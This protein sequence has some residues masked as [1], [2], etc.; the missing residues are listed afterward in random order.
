MLWLALHFPQLPLELLKGQT[1]PAA[2]IP[3]ADI[4]AADIAAADARTAHVVLQNNRVLQCDATASTAGIAI[5]A[6]LATAHS[7]YNKIVHGHR[8]IENEARRLR[9]LA[10]ALYRFSGHVSIQSPDC[11]LLEIGGSL[12]LF[13]DPEQV[14]DAAIQLCQDLGHC[15]QARL[16]CTPWAAIALARSGRRDVN[17][18]PLSLAGLELAGIDPS[19]IERFANMGIHT[20]EPLLKLPAKSL[21]K[22]FGKVLL[23]YIGQLSGAVPDPR[24]AITLP[25]AFEQQLH[26]LQPIRDKEDL[27]SH[28]RSPLIRLA[29]ELQHWLIAQ[30]L[31]CEELRW[32]FTR[33]GQDTVRVPVRFAKPQQNSADF[34]RVSQLTLEQLEL[35]EEVLSIT[36]SASRLRPWRNHSQNLFSV[37]SAHTGSGCENAD[38]IGAIIDEFN[39]R[40]GQGRCFGMQTVTQYAPEAAC[41]S[42]KA[43]KSQRENA[44]VAEQQQRFFARIGKRPL[45]L[46]DAPRP[47]RREDL[48]LLQGPERIQSSWWTADTVCRDYYIA[49]HS[50]GA[51]CWVFVQLFGENPAEKTLSPTE[52]WY[53]HGYFG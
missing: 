26:L 36:L 27:C 42:A 9:Q 19:I 15:S 34:W 12:K 29:R 48:V 2:D 43:L 30:Q 40:L 52:N 50:L 31:G 6:T 17:A 7:I 18:V 16:A 25:P 24:R 10:Q 44:S 13:G 4:A 38:E 8:N 21:G 41:T 53:V 45:W 28:T 35:P 39:A 23:K 46:F 22:R 14:S 33:H 1:A 5:D 37:A 47:I 3:A 49:L 32:S 11:I 51:E 20:L